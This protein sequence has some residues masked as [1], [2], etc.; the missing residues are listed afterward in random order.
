MEPEASVEP[1]I[2]N[3]TH[4]RDFNCNFQQTMVR[5]SCSR[6]AENPPWASCSPDQ[7][8]KTNVR[9]ASSYC[10]SRRS[11]FQSELHR[12]RKN[13]RNEDVRPIDLAHVDI[14]VTV[15]DL[16]L[17][18]GSAK[19]TSFLGIGRID[20]IDQRERV[21]TCP[22]YGRLRDLEGSCNRGF[23]GCDQKYK[24][25]CSGAVGFGLGSE[26]STFSPATPL[27]LN[28]ARQTRVHE[29][30]LPTAYNET[31]TRT[32]LAERYTSLGMGK[33]RDLIHSITFMRPSD[34]PRDLRCSGADGLTHDSDICPCCHWAYQARPL[35][36]VGSRLLGFIAPS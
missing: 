31:G 33:V 26:Q 3:Q 36:Y 18:D 8:Y 2:I 16:S 12:F 15:S 25:R 23:C 11:P 34:N 7:V 4:S 35:V 6:V 24:E 30:N 21:L 5:Q 1:R 9:K 20:C 10:P 28:A 32:I 14:D 29:K 13:S 22:A 19:L 17:I 27:K